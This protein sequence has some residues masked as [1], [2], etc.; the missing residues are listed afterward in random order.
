MKCQ[1]GDRLVEMLAIPFPFWN[2]LFFCICELM[3]LYML[4]PAVIPSIPTHQAQP[5]PLRLT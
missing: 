2:C 3:A 1:K 5:S 4:N